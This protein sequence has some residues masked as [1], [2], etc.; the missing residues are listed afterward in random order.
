MSS[1]PDCRHARLHIG[2]APGE[3][4]PDVTAHLATCVDCS[5]FRDETLALDRGV[6]GALEVPL[7]RFREAAPAV[8]RPPPARRLALA[9]SVVL[10][11]VMAGGFWLLNPR[12]ALAGEIAAHV[13]HEAGSWDKH[14]PVS[15]EALGSV[16][17]QA[18]V[19]FD[20]SMPVVYVMSCPFRGGHV[21]HL[22]VQT[23]SGPL[24]VMLLPR[25]KIATRTEFSEH[26]Y[27]G[28]LL[29]A[30]G[31]GIAVLTRGTEVPTVLAEQITSAVRW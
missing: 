3:L 20:S 2:A 8:H 12:P 29:P 6:R 30:G 14:E 11:L 9:A 13:D 17:R 15:A 10:A 5:R 26:G 1:G 24:T 27:H 25:E 28:V 18:G 7:A 31:G 16:L 21:P 4:P 19:S 23:D 22:V